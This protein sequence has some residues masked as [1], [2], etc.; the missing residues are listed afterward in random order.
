MTKARLRNRHSKPNILI[1]M[2]TNIL[3]GGMRYGAHTIQ[4]KSLGISGCAAT[5]A[6]FHAPLWKCDRTNAAYKNVPD[7]FLK[8]GTDGLAYGVEV[9]DDKRNPAV[10]WS[11][12]EHNDEKNRPRSTD[13]GSSLR[14]SSI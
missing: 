2:Q 12:L 4:P 5:G 10:L 6:L 14:R 13:R 9:A 7:I 1:K 8:L 11:V 3:R